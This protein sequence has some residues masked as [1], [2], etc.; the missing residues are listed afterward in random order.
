[1]NVYTVGALAHEFAR[2]MRRE[3]TGE[4]MEQ[5]LKNARM[6]HTCKTHD[7]CDANQIMLDALTAMNGG[8]QVEFVDELIPMITAAWDIARDN[9][10]YVPHFVT[11]TGYCE[12]CGGVCM[13][14]I[15]A[16]AEYEKQNLVFASAQITLAQYMKMEETNA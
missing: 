9:R 16:Y 15:K 11:D 13:N 4:Q 2:L 12:D 14:V 8:M 5:V 1:M 3:L 7:F 6:V 10:W